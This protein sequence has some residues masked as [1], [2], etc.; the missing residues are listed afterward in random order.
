M[1]KEDGDEIHFKISNLGC[2]IPTG[3]KVFVLSEKA[4][5]TPFPAALTHLSSGCMH[6]SFAMAGIS[7]GLHMNLAVSAQAVSGR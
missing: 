4:L 7:C 1:R 3:F 6:S 5:Q 2:Q